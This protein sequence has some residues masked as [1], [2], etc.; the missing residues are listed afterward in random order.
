[1]SA[2]HL[3]MNLI[4]PDMR[5]LFVWGWL[6]L[7]ALSCTTFRVYFNTYYNA[8]RLFVDAERRYQAEGFS[9]A[10][11]DQYNKVIEKSVV[12]V[13]YFPTS[14]YVDD[15]LYMMGVSYLRLGDPERAVRRF[16]ELLTYFPRSPLRTRALLGLAEAYILSRD[17]EEAEALLKQI[18]PVRSGEKETLFRLQLMLSKETHHPRAFLT[19]MDSLVATHPDAASRDLLLEAV[20]VAREARDFDRARRYLE[21]YQVRFGQEQ[22]RREALEALGDVSRDEGHL[23]QALELYRSLDPPPGSEMEARV[24]WKIARTLLQKGDTSEALQTL[25][26]LVGG[27]L[28]YAEQQQAALF[29]AERALSQG[30]TEKA[31][32]Y[33]QKVRMGPELS[34]RQ[35]AE[36]RLAGLDALTVAMK[37]TTASGA[38][39]RAQIYTFDLDRPDRARQ[40]LDSLLQIATLPDTIRL[41]AI[42]LRFLLHQDT[43]EAESLRALLERLDPTG[44]YHPETYGTSP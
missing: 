19:A 39:H 12:I 38:L 2:P 23:E 8:H 11:R 37:D 34:L 30:Q 27:A 18:H 4:V 16:Q 3:P 15:A 32:S 22:A 5:R 7:L 26:T 28:R 1:M 42:Y 43:T 9:P 33:L 21:L 20:H 10:L 36:R 24:H 17:L 35:L 25:Q 41:P 14:R 44:V 6:P 29:L 40:L 31:R 13:R